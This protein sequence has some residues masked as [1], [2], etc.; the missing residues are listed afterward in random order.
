[1]KVSFISY[2]AAIF[3]AFS[4]N[5]KDL[6]P[7]EPQENKLTFTVDGEK[8][9]SYT[10]KEFYGRFDWG[11]SWGSA[12][13]L[14]STSQNFDSTPGIYFTAQGKNEQKE[15]EYLIS[16]C[17]FSE[18]RSNGPY[19]TKV[20]SGKFHITYLSADQYKWTGDFS[21]EI[22]DTAINKTKTIKGECTVID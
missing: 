9:Y 7:G 10:G 20:K 5:K 22:T 21:F 12:L 4:C 18:D 13:F 6:L 14:Y 2:I 3:I 19:Y 16:T 1:M 8:K 11:Y 17:S 15:G